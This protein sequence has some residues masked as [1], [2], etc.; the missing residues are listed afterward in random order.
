MKS[1]NRLEFEL[2]CVWRFGILLY[3]TDTH[4]RWCNFSL[5]DA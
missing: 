2:R 3:D 5:R 4:K 1:N